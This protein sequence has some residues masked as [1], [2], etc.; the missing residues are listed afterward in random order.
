MVFESIK[1]QPGGSLEPILISSRKGV[2]LFRDEA[3]DCGFCKGKGEK[4]M[5]SICS[6]CKGKKQI[7]LTPPVVKCAACKGKGEERRN[8]NITCTPCRGTGWVA[9]TEPVEKC[10]SCHGRGKTRG[11]NLPCV[12]CKGVGVVTI[13]Q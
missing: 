3:Y 5:G 13:N 7:I 11:S 8:T 12:K 10:R 9:V 1:L 6:A 4:P 2:E